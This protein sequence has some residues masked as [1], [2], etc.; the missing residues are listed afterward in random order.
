MNCGAVRGSATEAAVPP[1]ESFAAPGPVKPAE[2]AR[3]PAVAV[4]LVPTRDAGRIWSM[5]SP[6]SKRPSSVTTSKASPASDTAA[7]KPSFSFS[8]TKCTRAPGTSAALTGAAV[9]FAPALGSAT[10]R[11]LQ[12]LRRRLA[13]RSAFACTSP[14]AMGPS[15]ATLTCERKV[16]RISASPPCQ[17]M[18]VQAFATDVSARVTGSLSSSHMSSN[19]TSPGNSMFTDQTGAHGSATPTPPRPQADTGSGSSKSGSA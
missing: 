18:A 17:P 2:R 3:S 11:H 15:P 16:S 19:G 13:T 1:A 9:V 10:T 14:R 7:T 12:A 4:V 5:G 6:C 8:N